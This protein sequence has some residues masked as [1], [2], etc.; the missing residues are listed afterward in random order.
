MKAVGARVAISLWVLLLC[1]IAGQPSAAGQQ[2][3]ADHF[4]RGKEL[5]QKADLDGAVAEYR[6][7]VRLKP[8]FAEGYYNLGVA[9]Q[10][11]GDRTAAIAAYRKA[12]ALNSKFPEALANLG[13]A[14]ASKGE[15]DEAVGAYREALK[16]NPDNGQ[17]HASLGVA[18]R[19]KGDEEAA[20]QEFQE[21]RR[22]DPRL[23]LPPPR[24]TLPITD[25]FT[26]E[27]GWPSGEMET[28]SYGCERSAYRMH[29]KKAGPVHVVR[30]F[31]L[32][33]PAV[34]AE[35][36]AGVDTGAGAEPGR[37]LFGIGCLTDG[38][39]G[40]MAMVKTD[41]TWSIVRLNR[42]FTPLAGENKAGNIPKLGR[43]N[44]VRI[45]CNGGRERATVVSF[46]VN[47]QKVG[48]VEDEQ[49]YGWFNG[50]ALYADTFPGV[51]VFQRFVAR[52]PTS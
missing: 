35:V 27:C 23:G 46:F 21:A 36:D 4:H 48:S 24:G 49:G 40:Y 47:G 26:G 11:K 19:R 14:L 6:E 45:V 3:A 13:G 39:H 33:V 2:T 12:L 1:V 25:D 20:G 22:L 50:F 52:Q 5:Y 51:V 30:S 15:I 10:E 17:I 8:D 9:L 31:A 42:S 44:R 16:L 34:S 38:S 32:E 7:A 43:T 28:F 37:A 18:L 41:G 29:V